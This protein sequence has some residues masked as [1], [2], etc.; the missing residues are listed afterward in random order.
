MPHSE[1]LPVTVPRL[2]WLTAALLGLATLAPGGLAQTNATPAASYPELPSEIPP[3]FEPTRDTFDHV[4]REVK[5]PMRDGVKLHTVIL[6]PKGA[7]AAPILLTRTPYDADK[8]TSHQE[9]AHLGPVLHGYDNATDVI[10]GGWVHPGG[11]GCPRE[12]RVGRRLRDQPAV[13]RAAEPDAGGP[14]DGHVGHH[15][16]AG[17]GMSRSRTARWG[18]SG[19]RYNGFL[20]LAALVDPH[21]ALKVAVPMNPMVDGWRGDDWFHYGAFRQ[22]NVF[23]IYRQVATRKSEAQ[24]WSAHHDV[25]DM[26]MEAVSAGGLGRRAGWRRSVSGASS[27]STRPTTRSGATRRWINCWR[28]NR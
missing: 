9:S 4:R 5:I 11:A 3:A 16:V 25:Y 26:F 6:V 8:L 17:C 10:V 18:S 15:R 20:A 2:Q 19:F 23:W 1:S 21:P 22:L 7:Q 14:R 24:W 13:P 28:R 27:R 12:T